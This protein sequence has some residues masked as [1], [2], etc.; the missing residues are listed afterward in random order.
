M[1]VSSTLT[2]VSYSGNGSTTSFAVSFPFQGTGATAELEVVE[3][4]IATGA[5]T[6][7]SYTTHY[8]V[9]GGNGSTGTVTA[10]SAPADTVQWHIRRTTTRTQ[11]VDYTANDPF[12]ADTHELALDRLAMATQELQ[13][14]S[15]RSFKVSR[16][17][18]I[19]TPEFVDNAATRASKLL[20]FDSDG[21][22]EATTGRVSSV[23]V[24]N[25]ATSSGAPGTATAS[26]TTSSGALALGI[27]IG[28]TGHAGISMQYSTTTADADPG[29]GFIRLNNAS[30]NSATIMY[31]DDSDGTTDISAWV[32]SWDNSTSGSKG[33]ITIAGNPNSSSPLVIF[34][35]NGAVT[36]AS[37][38]T[39]VPVAYVAGSTSISNSAEISV[40]FSPAGDGDV[41]GL[42][43]TFSTTTTD[44]DPG[45]GT[46]RLNHGTIG[47]ATAIYIDDSDANSADVSAYLLTW[48]DSTNTADRG[49]IYITKKSAPANY[50]IFKVS[51]ASTDASGY[52][53]LAVTH[54]DSNG[55]FSDADEIAVEFNR[56]GNAGD[57]QDP[58]TTRGDII[59][60]G[61]SA[62]GRLAV[63]SANRV[64]ISDGTDPAY[65]QVPL[66]T[67]VSGTLPVAN[68]G[69]GAT[70]LASANIV[71]TN[72][73]NTFTKAQLPSTHTAALSATSGVLDYDTYQN[74]IITLA[75]GSN[76]LAA[77]TTEAS[78]VGQC[79]V[80]IFVQPSSGSAATLSLHG[81]YETAAAAGITLSTANDDY[82]LVAYC[83]RA[84]N[85]ILLSQAQ[86][87]FG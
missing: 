37:G 28:Q 85:S 48:D 15:N 31:V 65:G 1:A 73:Q 63:G 18:A 87:N 58:T 78:Q 42:D 38:Y 11:T 5:E 25:V 70:S 40:Q 86:L 76:T 56:T 33:F 39:K 55:S 77:P 79:G 16:T 13:E 41:A 72:A 29:A 50:A 54:V 69:T 43:Y 64:L 75:A 10:A 17:N 2:T 36:D 62:I 32:Q 82:D 53:K 44:S 22:L 47:S 74:F 7:K 23:S 57:L 61:A 46:L 84:D 71:A 6:V 26:F 66:A 3:R 68:G 80:I 30:L 52:V 81:D 12:P 45:T 19:T 24:S 67:A 14:E 8:T 4:V 60:R 83:V 59:T 51:G 34:K 21:D 27:P 35:V 20:G 9:S 49:T